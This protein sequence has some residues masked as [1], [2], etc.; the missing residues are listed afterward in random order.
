MGQIPPPTRSQPG[1]SAVK[2]AG[3]V[4]SEA[5]R[6]PP[7]WTSPW[8]LLPEAPRPPAVFAPRTSCQTVSFAWQP[9]GRQ[10]V[11]PGSAR[12]L[13]TTGVQGTLEKL[14]PRPRHLPLSLEIQSPRLSPPGRRQ[15]PSRTLAPRQR[16]S[17]T[18]G[19]G[20]PP[21]SVR[22]CCLCPASQPC[23]PQRPA[24][25]FHAPSVPP[26]CTHDH[27]V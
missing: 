16:L 12:S 13:Q 4:V 18:Q 20:T 21:G 23:P 24:T 17:S 7:P 2:R 1:G 8:S 15:Q 25:R 3:G 11:R 5:Q 27:T 9:A 6:P 10:S 14:R 26:P 19:G 22:A